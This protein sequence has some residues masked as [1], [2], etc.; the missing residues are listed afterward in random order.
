MQRP[1]NK[2]GSS[3]F[4]LPGGLPGVLL[5]HGFTGDTSEMRGLAEMLNGMGLYCYAPL[6][7]GHGTQPQELFGLTDEHWLRA[8]REGLEHVKAQ[9]EQVIV[10]SFSMGAALSAIMLAQEARD[11]DWHRYQHSDQHSGQHEQV[12][13]FIAVAPLIATRVPLLLLSPILSQ[14]KPWFYPLKVTS[15]DMLGIRRKI[16][17]YD[18]TLNLDDPEVLARMRD[19][20]RIPIAVAGELRKIARQA[21][22]A[23]HHLS[24]PTLVAQGS[25][26][27]AV[28]PEG[29]RRF[30]RGLAATDRS[31]VTISGAK[32]DFVMPA[33]R[34]HAELLAAVQG[35]VRQ[36]FLA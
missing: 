6:L 25:A 34:G 22:Q 15:I 36:R 30:Y 7:P 2:N 28:D 35:W 32:H 33:T 17:Q 26:D 27:L 18:P 5:V 16:V 3:T 12:A 13:G 14:F 21:I 23:A 10:C 31:L 11:S 24:M 29:A 4:E 20:V 8:A 1:M 19:T 9:H